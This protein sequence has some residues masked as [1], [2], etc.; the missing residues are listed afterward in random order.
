VFLYASSAWVIGPT[1]GAVDESTAINPP[2]V[3]RR[4]FPAYCPP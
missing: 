2:E 3:V 1:R 4:A